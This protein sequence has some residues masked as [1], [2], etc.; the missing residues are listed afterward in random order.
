M[1]MCVLSYHRSRSREG[2]KPITVGGLTMMIFY[3]HNI[4]CNI[5][6]LSCILC[7]GMKII[8]AKNKRKWRIYVFEHNMS[9]LKKLTI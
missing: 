5:F 8:T 3:Y 4:I 1:L 9:V 2:S 6:M 7:K